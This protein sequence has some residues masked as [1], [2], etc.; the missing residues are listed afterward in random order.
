MLTAG[1]GDTAQTF[2]WLERAREAHDPFLVYNFVSDPLMDP[3]RR[4][5]RGAAILRAMGL[6]ETR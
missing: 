3:I 6:P 1:L 5:P 4:H 2:V